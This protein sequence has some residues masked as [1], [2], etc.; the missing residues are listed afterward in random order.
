MAVELHV[1]LL[2]RKRRAIGD[3][4]LFAHEIDAGDHLGD[5]VL[6]LQTRVHF[7]EI[8]FAVFVKILNRADAEIAE[9]LDRIGRDLADAR[10]LVRV[11]SWRRRFFE[12]F[13]VAALQRAIALAQMDDV[14]VAV[15][16][17][18][19]FDVTRLGEVFLHIDVVIAERGL[20]F[21]A[22]GGERF[23]DVFSGARDFH[24]A[25]AAARGGFDQHRI[26]DLFAPLLGFFFGGD[27][28]IGAGD[29]GHAGIDR[30]LLGGDFVA[31]QADVLGRWADEGH[32]VLRDYLGELGVLGKKAVA[33][34]DRLRA[35]D[36]GG[37]DDARNVQVGFAGWRR[38]DAHAL[39]GEAHVHGVRV[40]GGVHRDGRDAHFL[41]RAMDAQC[42]FAAVRDEDFF[43][44]R[45]L[46]ND[47]RLAV[48]DGLR[49]RDENGDD[50]ARA[51]RRDRIERL[52][53]FNDH[54]SLA[55]G[56]AVAN[57][58]EGRR[59]RLWREIGGADHW[60][61]HCAWMRRGVGGG[62]RRGG[63]RRC[64]GCCDMGRRCGHDMRLHGCRGRDQ[65]ARQTQAQFAVLNFD[66]AQAAIRKDRGQFAHKIGV[67]RLS[68]L[69]A[70]CLRFP[71]HAPL[72]SFANKAAA[73]MASRYEVA[74]KP[75]IT[76][77]A[78]LPTNET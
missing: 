41:A 24:A 50:L 10:A 19:N 20:G 14:A 23:H 78:A 5:R 39:I 8:E 11:Q 44:H 37:R 46:E 56:D 21:G 45:L 1:L 61:R 7:D 28:A 75:A 26:A 59:T 29:D 67:D 6:N 22:C 51:R 43:E 54:Q 2:H 49:I 13:L 73:S 74:P 70:H 48:F 17:D 53:R 76:P 34:M 47:Q 68:L 63:R 30:G 66:F 77:F 40:R 52:H 32:A 25:P 71:A 65:G 31:H 3:A 38:A 62:R 55:S 58:D 12:H 4:D 64:G 16:D 42:N 33:R 36:F 27:A 72:L 57:F 69:L 18:L 35:G 60:G 9:L 15:G